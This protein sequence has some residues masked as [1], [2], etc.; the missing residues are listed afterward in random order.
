MKQDAYHF[1][2]S[3]GIIGALPTF[4]PEQVK[5]EPMLFSCDADAAYDMGGP[6]TRAFLSSLGDS[7]TMRRDFIMDSRVHMLMRGWYPCIPGWHHDDVPRSSPDGQ[8]NYDSPEYKAEHALALVGD[9]CPTEFALGRVS[10]PGL[11]NGQVI[12]RTWHREVEEAVRLGKLTLLQASGGSIYSFDASTFHQ[13]RPA[14][15]DGWRWFGRASIR[16]HRKPT[17][18]LRRQTQVYLE[19]PME[20]W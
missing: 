16:T 5:N 20:G 11:P 3:V 9:C 6:I 2:S 15:H 1:R 18:E 10:L 12:Y 8:P 7:W 17:N 14:L 13:G 4:T 19:F